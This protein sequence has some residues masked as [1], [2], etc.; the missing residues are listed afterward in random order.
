[1]TYVGV[2]GVNELTCA[3]RVST[4][5]HTSSD[6]LMI[7]SL[8]LS[9]TLQAQEMQTSDHEVQEAAIQVRSFV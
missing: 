7:A 6:V 8:S 3:R 4:A 2:N 1:M 5:D 9:A